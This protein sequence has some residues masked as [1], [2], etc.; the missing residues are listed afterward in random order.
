MST[1]ATRERLLETGRSS[2]RFSLV[3]AAL[4][5]ALLPAYTIRWHIGPLPTTLLENAIWLTVAVFAAETLLGRQPIEWRTSFTVPAVLFLVAGLIDVVFAPDR[6]AALGLY[7]AYLVEPMAVF[8]VLATATRTVRQAFLILGGLAVGGIALSIPNAAIVI[9][10]IR[11]HTLNLAG[12]PPVAIYQTQNAVALFLL[13]LI[14]LA[15]SLLL[16]G[17]NPERSASVVF[18]VVAVPTFLLTLSRGG[19]LAIGAVALGLALTH[20]RRI[21]I[22]ALMALAAALFTRIPAVATRLAHDLNF[23]DPS[24][25]LVGRVPLWRATL[26]MLRHNPL[27]GAGLSGFETR[28]A[29]YWNATHVDRFIY[30]HNILLNFW[31]ATGILGVVSFGWLMLQAF[32]LSW[33][34]WR[35]GDRAFA[36]IELGVFLALVGI[37]VHGL[38]DVP[39]FKNDLSLE[40]WVLLALCWAGV[41]WAGGG[42]TNPTGSRAAP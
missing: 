26:Q 31:A 30:P 3:C 19:Y 5:C 42:L 18:L 23:A 16:Y 32:R 28:I 25:T 20:R 8:V 6:R 29:P 9:E 14:A 38:V 36:S 11:H 39:Y 37:V 4:S 2:Y 24:N 12:T 7:R 21:L 34:G 10:A 41:R 17:R 27:F 15:A 1:V 40:F 22:V 13:P 33:R 35:Y